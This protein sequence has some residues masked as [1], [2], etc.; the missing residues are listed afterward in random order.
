[1]LTGFTKYKKSGKVLGPRHQIAQ[2]VELH[3]EADSVDPLVDGTDLIQQLVEATADARCWG[4]LTQSL[5]R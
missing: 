2:I 1:M 4:S 5:K 3:E